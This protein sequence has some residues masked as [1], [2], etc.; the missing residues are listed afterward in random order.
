MAWLKNIKLVSLGDISDPLEF[1]RHCCTLL[2][3]D[4]FEGIRLTKA[5]GDFGVDILASGMDGSYAIQCKLYTDP[6]GV[7]AVQEVV[8]GKFFL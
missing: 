2:Q 3:V 8:A 1:E 6:V 7:H 4:G 5:S